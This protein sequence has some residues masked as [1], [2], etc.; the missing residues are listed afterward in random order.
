MGGNRMSAFPEI[1][2]LKGLQIMFLWL[3]IRG[4]GPKRPYN[5]GC[6]KK[7]F[8]IELVNQPASA[9]SQPVQDSGAPLPCPFEEEVR[10]QCDPLWAKRMD[11]AKGAGWLTNSILKFFLGHPVDQQ[12]LKMY[13]ERKKMEF[14][15]IQ[16]L[17]LSGIFLSGN[18][19]TPHPP[20]TENHPAQKPSAD[21]G[22]TPPPLTNNP[23]I[24]FKQN[25][26]KRA[27]ISVFW[28]KI[29]VF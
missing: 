2:F 3:I 13:E 15:D 22:G 6:P 19:G 10:T 21:M 11:N 8:K 26:S 16:Y 5:T 24:F 18:G 12:G 27:N 14:S 23:Q 9:D 20:L 25:W 1:F 28:P 7:N 29:A 4:N 17:L